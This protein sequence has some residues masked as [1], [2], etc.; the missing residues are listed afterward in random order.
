MHGFVSDPSWCVF[1]RL[2]VSFCVAGVSLRAPSLHTARNDSMENASERPAGADNPSER[3]RIDKWLWA[4]R[5]FKTRSI[6]A[7]A[8]T[9]G[10]VDLNG[11][12]VKPAKPV[13]IGDVLRVRK[14]VFEWEVTVHKLGQRRGSATLAQELYVESEA[15][16]QAR[17]ELAERMRLEREAAPPPPKYVKG[18]PTK[19]DRR[20]M[21]RLVERVKGMDDEP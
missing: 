3:V 7:E 17:A 4:A 12:R 13:K 10:K 8:V 18:R 21:D 16:K 2:A 20:Q 14:G 15:S 9:G 6:A 19:R 5:F 11:E 1:A